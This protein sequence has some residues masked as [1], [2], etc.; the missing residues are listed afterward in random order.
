MKVIFYAKF[1]IHPTQYLRRVGREGARESD[2]IVQHAVQGLHV[3]LQD[4]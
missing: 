1:R 3:R 4:L 2:V